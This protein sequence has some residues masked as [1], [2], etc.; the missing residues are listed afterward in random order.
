MALWGKTDDQSG[1]IH[2][3]LFHMLDAGNV[4]A[5][6]WSSALPGSMKKDLASILEV[7]LDSAGR[8]IAWWTALHDLGKAGPAFQKKHPP[9]LGVLIT[10]GFTFPPQ[11]SFPERPH[12]LVT[13]W[14]LSSAS[15]LPGLTP[16]ETDLLGRV[17]AGHHGLWPDSDTFDD[18]ARAANLGDVSWRSA[19]KDLCEILA[20]VFTPPKKYSFPEEGLDRN[21]FLTLLSG[22]VSVA[23]WLASMQSIF[24]AAGNEV[25]WQSYLPVSANNARKAVEE[26]GWQLWNDPSDGLPL[27]FEQLF[28]VNSVPRPVQSAVFEHASDISLPALALIEAPTGIGKT[29]IAFVLADRWLKKSGGRGMYIA[30]PTQATSNQMFNRT[31]AFLSRRFDGQTVHL[32]LAH[33]HALLQEDFEKTII[34][35]VGEETQAGIA[36]ASWFLP[37]KRTLLAPYGVGTVDQVFLSVLQT[38]HFFVRLFGLYGKVLVF[39][40]VHAYDAYQSE[41]FARLLGW[42]RVLKVSV[43]LLSATL[44]AQVRSQMVNAYGGKSMLSLAEGGYPRLTLVGPDGV[45]VHSLP[46]SPSQPVGLDWIGGEPADIVAYLIEKLAEGGC[47]AVICNTVSRAQEIYQ[48]VA[49]AHVAPGATTLFHARFPF[50]WRDKIEKRVVDTFGPGVSRPQR[51][52]VVATQVIEQSLDLDFDLM[53]SELAP[54]DLLIQR[55]GRLHR[56]ACSARPAPVSVRCLALIQAKK[57]KDGDPDFGPSSYVYRE[58]HLLRTQIALN[59]RTDLLLPAETPTLIESVYGDGMPAVDKGTADKLARARSEMDKAIRDSMLEARKRLVLLPGKD[60][61]LLRR[62]E[63]LLEE[64]DP[65]AHPALQA[66][67]REAPP[68]VRLVCLH[69]LPGGETALEPGQAET[70]IDINRKPAKEE[71]KKLLQ[72]VVQVQR[73][74]L[75]RYFAEQPPHA[76]WK[77]IAALRYHYPVVFTDGQQQFPDLKLALN[78]DRELGLSFQKEAV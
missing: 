14:A 13:G 66:L 31:G 27:R 50:T 74:E 76:A 41:L 55:A 73:P 64:E 56:H 18:P 15:F 4:A 70:V 3:L 16:D 65:S 48:A 5:T 75:V 45:D 33:G 72:H 46:E 28:P 19:R 1:E 23:D 42:L 58:Y 69:H 47:A 7:D 34:T 11:A 25:E 8:L 61:L 57:T 9:A 10:N 32:Q 39:D 38:R 71:I 67:T 52:V 49:D 62:S 40:E 54:I 26:Q 12:G 60:D 20:S 37:R 17:L 6:L 51:A 21:I 59:G 43:I 24:P 30:M 22:L 44:P 77:G 35:S 36:A 78:L 63:N 53:I 29:E 2:P 68:G